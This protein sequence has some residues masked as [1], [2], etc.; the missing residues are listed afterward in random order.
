MV[1]SRSSVGGA[2]GDDVFASTDLSVAMPF[3]SL[4]H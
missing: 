3:P 4:G 1:H 2:L